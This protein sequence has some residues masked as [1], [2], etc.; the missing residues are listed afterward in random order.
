MILSPVNTLLNWIKEF[1]TWLKYT[2]EKNIKIYEVFSKNHIEERRNVLK[3]WHR[4]GGVMI[5]V[6]EIFRNLTNHDAKGEYDK[7]FYEILLSPGPD[8]LV[9]DE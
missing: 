8:L 1:G 4:N 6:Y 9:C 3:K 2:K 5:L 7:E